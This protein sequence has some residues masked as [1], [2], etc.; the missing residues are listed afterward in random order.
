MFRCGIGGSD[1]QQC[2]ICTLYSWGPKEGEDDQTDY[3]ELPSVAGEGHRTT[4]AHLSREDDEDLMNIVRG[5]ERPRGRP[6]ASRLAAPRETKASSRNAKKDERA[7]YGTRVVLHSMTTRP[8]LNGRIGTVEGATGGSVRVVLDG[9]GQTHHVPARN[10]ATM[11]GAPPPPPRNPRDSTD[12]VELNH[13]LAAL[14]G[15]RNSI[16]S[17]DTFQSAQ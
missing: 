4:P 9:D 7:V 2:E 8:A 16:V 1:A 10:L 6:P 13:G 3:R 11:S 15:D 12:T 5:G 17:T 14:G